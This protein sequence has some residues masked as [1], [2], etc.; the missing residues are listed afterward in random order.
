MI[1]RFRQLLSRVASVNK[2]LTRSDCSSFV[3]DMPDGRSRE[4][5]VGRVKLSGMRLMKLFIARAP[6]FLCFGTALIQILH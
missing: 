1:P 3:E 5:H 6:V 2:Q 4:V